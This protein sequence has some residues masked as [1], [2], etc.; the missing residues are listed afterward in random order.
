[1]KN[2]LLGNFRIE[3]FK[4][5]AGPREV[6]CRMRLDIDGIPHVTAI[7]KSTGKP[8]DIPISATLALTQASET[9]TNRPAQDTERTL[10]GYQ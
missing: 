5:T 6:L 2:A 3:G 9:I 1:M 4:P 10:E 8:K 7:G